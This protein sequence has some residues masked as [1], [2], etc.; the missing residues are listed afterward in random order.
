MIKYRIIHTNTVC[1]GMSY[2][3]A[4][5]TLQQLRDAYPDYEYDIEEYN[6]VSPDAKRYGRDPDLH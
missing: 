3:D 5:S 1:D 4:L 2:D 6:Y